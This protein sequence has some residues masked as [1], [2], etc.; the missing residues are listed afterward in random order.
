MWR[1]MAS[2]LVL[3][4]QVNALAPARSRAS[5]GLVGDD[6]HASRASDHNPHYVEGV[7]RDIV[8]ALDLTHDPAGGFDS[9]AFAEVLRQHRDR[10]IKY[11]ISNRRIFS[12]GSWTWRAYAGTDPH[13]NHVHISV[14]DDPISD[15]RTPWNLEGFDMALT[16]DDVKFMWTE[17][18][19]GSATNPT[20]LLK[21]LKAATTLPPG[22]EAKLDAILAAAL[23][24][25]DTTVVLPPDGIAA[26]EEIKAAIAA[27]PTAEENADAVLDAE[28]ARLAE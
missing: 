12:S 16:A 2:L 25:G 1:A 18:N 14:L 20:T 17:W 5:D 7:G 11:V 27:V 24:D 6:D 28:A 19:A 23:D 21:L 3:R 26:L 10:R 4:D 22:T 8:T 15:T 9:F 13:I